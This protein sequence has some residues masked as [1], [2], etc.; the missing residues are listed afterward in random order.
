M[1]KDQ[2]RVR[3]HRML[4]GVDGRRFVFGREFD[5]QFLVA[6]GLLAVGNRCC[7]RELILSYHRAEHTYRSYPVYE[8][9]EREAWP[10]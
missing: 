2:T 9:S 5:K 3:D 1:I 10:C 7:M 6:R 4:L 8:E